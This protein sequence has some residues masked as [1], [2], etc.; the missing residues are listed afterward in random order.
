[1]TFVSWLELGLRL[2]PGVAGAVTFASEWLIHPPRR[3]ALPTQSLADA[4]SKSIGF[5]LL[6]N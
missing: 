5:E 2:D 6:P 3:A 4:M 1:M